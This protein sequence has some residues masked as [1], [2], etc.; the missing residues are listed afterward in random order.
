V[1]SIKGELTAIM[2]KP[3]KESD[4]TW[5]MVELLIPGAQ[6]TVWSRDDGIPFPD[7]NAEPDPDDLCPEGNVTKQFWKNLNSGIERRIMK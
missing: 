5:D 1:G 6:F 3:E 7:L 2:R 4:V